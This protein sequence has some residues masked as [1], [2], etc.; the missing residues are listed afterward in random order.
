MFAGCV[1][2]ELKANAAILNKL[3]LIK[4][5]QVDHNTSVKVLKRCFKRDKICSPA[6]WLNTFLNLIVNVWFFLMTTV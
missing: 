1:S 2:P 5:S 4:M 3:D 6:I